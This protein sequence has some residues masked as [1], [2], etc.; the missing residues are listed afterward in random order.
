MKKRRGKPKL[1]NCSYEDVIR[2]LKKI[3]HFLI[4]KVGKHSRVTHKPTNKP[5]TLPRSSPIDRHLLRDFVEDYLI[6]E[7]GYSEKVIYQYLWC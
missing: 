7:L 1:A 2:A 5:S 3:G 4:K 6:K